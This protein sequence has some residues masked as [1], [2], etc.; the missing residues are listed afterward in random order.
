MEKGKTV[1]WGTCRHCPLNPDPENFPP[2][3]LQR[4]RIGDKVEAAA[5]RM[6]IEPCGGCRKR[7]AWLNGYVR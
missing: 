6:G 3:L 1:S 4:V 2:S 5:K 7:K